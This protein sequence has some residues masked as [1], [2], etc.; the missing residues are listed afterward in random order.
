MV[1]FQRLRPRAGRREGLGS[2]LAGD[3]VAVAV[4]IFPVAGFTEVDRRRS[5]GSRIVTSLPEVAGLRFALTSQ[6]D[7]HSDWADELRE[8]GAPAFVSG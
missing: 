3:P 8:L 4:H 1:R 2:G 5:S 6:T 7:G